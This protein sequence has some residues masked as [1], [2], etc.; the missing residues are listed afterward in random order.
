VTMHFWVWYPN[1]AG[2]FMSENPLIAPFN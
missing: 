2:I 1:P